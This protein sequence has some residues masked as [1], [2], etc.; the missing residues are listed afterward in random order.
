MEPS[1]SYKGKRR[2]GTINYQR[3]I[4]YGY[5]KYIFYVLKDKQ[6]VN[7]PDCALSALIETTKSTKGK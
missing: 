5:T 6:L 7:T 2:N 1:R 3:T 4:V